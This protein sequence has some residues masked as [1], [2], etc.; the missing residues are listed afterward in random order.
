MY[1]NMSKEQRRSQCLTIVKSSSVS[2]SLNDFAVPKSLAKMKIP[3]TSIAKRIIR[4]FRSASL[5]APPLAM[6]PVIWSRMRRM[7]GNV[8][9][10]ACTQAGNQHHLPCCFPSSPQSLHA[11]ILRRLPGSH[12]LGRYIPGGLMEDY[13]S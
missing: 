8:S 3:V 6:F 10:H 12:L 1:T 13:A 11:G 9:L 5:P 7:A 2:A 4:L